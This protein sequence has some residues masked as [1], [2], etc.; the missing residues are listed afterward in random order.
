MWNL[1]KHGKKKAI[2]LENGNFITYN[3][4]FF[5][6]NECQSMIKDRE[7]VFLL[8]DQSM[9][10][11]IIYIA[12]IQN[13]IPVML[14]ESEMPTVITDNLIEQYRPC[15]VWRSDYVWDRI[16]YKK[17]N[18]FHKFSLYYNK[19]N[20]KCYTINEELA[21]IL[22]TSGSTGNTKGVCLSYENL[23][24]NTEAIIEGL[25]ICDT[26]RAMVM[27]PICYSYGLSIVNTYLYVGATLLLP[28]SN[29]TQKGFW[30]FFS[31]YNGTAICGVPYM[32]DL[33]MKLGFE[34][35]KINSLRLITQA[36]GK[37]SEKT[38]M[39]YLK[40]AQERDIKLAIMY[41]QTEATAR[42][43]LH[44]LDER[45]DKINSVGK[46]LPGGDIKIN[47][48]GEIIFFGSNVFMGYAATFQDLSNTLKK[49]NILY[50]G[51]I[52]YIDDDGYLYI[53]GRITRFAKVFG[54]RL[55]M[56]DIQNRLRNLSG[57]ELYCI[58]GKE[59]IAVCI[60]DVSKKEKVQNAINSLVINRNLFRIFW[61]H[62]FP[63]NSSGKILYKILEK[64]WREQVIN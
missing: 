8:A 2:L 37:L 19:K 5:R 50:T 56:D 28:K 1:E 54:M 49:Q 33:L 52:G 20:E 41:G 43:S 34:N 57:V 14:I 9:E 4:L 24:S 39:Y 26:D 42:I 46:A 10:S 44:F 13:K 32:Y 38:E 48:D 3:E 21:L 58:E 22:L 35:M 62:I 15:Y 40:Y 18:G 27:L 30:N 63:R 12:C 6:Q 61:V 31:L 53:S 16:D 59:Y 64:L 7:L 29:F 60:D 36:G 25:K 51:D 11:I 23:Q 55:N 17:V 45:P 47:S